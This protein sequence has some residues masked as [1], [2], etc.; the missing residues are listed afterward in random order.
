MREDAFLLRQVTSSDLCCVTANRGSAY[1]HIR[2]L[3]ASLGFFFP[4]FPLLARSLCVN[5]SRRCRPAISSGPGRRRREGRPA[6]AGNSTGGNGSLGL[7]LA[8]NVGCVLTLAANSGFP[9]LQFVSEM[10]VLVRRRTLP[11]AKHSNEAHG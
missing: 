6:G 1:H 8:E 11:S 5:I 9:R 2:A 10:Q 7:K 3:T 4:L